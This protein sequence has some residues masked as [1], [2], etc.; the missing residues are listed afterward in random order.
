MVVLALEHECQMCLIRR[1]PNPLRFF[2]KEFFVQHERRWTRNN[3]WV[4]H[5]LYVLFS[6]HRELCIRRKRLGSG[7]YFSIVIKEDFF[8]QKVFVTHVFLGASPV[9]LTTVLS[10]T[11]SKPTS[12]FEY[13]AF[14]TETRKLLPSEREVISK[15][16]ERSVLPER[17]PDIHKLEMRKSLVSNDRKAKGV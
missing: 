12:R 5:P 16:T 9:N 10:R 15:M 2:S 6:I 14:T 8:C 11:A 17:L 13:S 1:N 7:R 3:R 4:L